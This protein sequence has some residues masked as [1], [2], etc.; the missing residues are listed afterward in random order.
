MKKQAIRA[1]TRNPMTR[2]TNTD[3]FRNIH[4]GKKCFV[5]G[6]GTSLFGKDLSGIHAYP[7]VSVNS[8]ALLMPWDEP[9]DPLMRFWVSTDIL[10]MQW[11]YFWGKVARFDC[12]RLV[13][14]SWSRSSKELKG[15]H[16]NY[17]APRKS[18]Q[19]P[20]WKDDGLLAGSS[21]LTAIDLSLLMGCKQVILLG[22]DHKMINGNSHFWQNWP[23]VDRPKK[24]GKPDT[25]E[26]CQR[27]QGRV[28]KS[29]MRSFDVLN[30][31]SLT[32]GAKIYNA[33]EISTVFAF[34][35]ISLE[36]ALQ[37]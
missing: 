20:N 1:R 35:K 33:S 21:I 36:D 32:L 12:T 30:K 27:Q 7:V 15:L 31:Y 9:G 22:V 25:F 3:Q 19:T 11:D 13:R 2:E 17:Y 5:C 28:F 23:V 6:A 26:P 16:M 29:N 18:I 8:S 24:A 4:E 34:D 37:L 14:N 10:C